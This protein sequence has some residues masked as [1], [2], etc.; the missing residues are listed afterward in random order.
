M[1]QLMKNKRAST[2]L[3]TMRLFLVR[4]LTLLVWCNGSMP[5]PYGM[6]GK[7]GSTPT[8]ILIYFGL[9]ILL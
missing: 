5:I 8:A 2:L 4:V 3:T 9:E 7:V 1:D 6:G